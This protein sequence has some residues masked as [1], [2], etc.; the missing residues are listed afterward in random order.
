MDN[1]RCA[2]PFPFECI[3]ANWPPAPTRKGQP[4][5]AAGQSGGGGRKNR[6]VAPFLTSYWSLRCLAAAAEWIPLCRSVHPRIFTLH[7]VI[8]LTPAFALSPPACILQM[9]DDPK[10]FDPS[11]AEGGLHTVT[12]MTAVIVGDLDC[13]CE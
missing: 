6:F 2:R 3:L 7:S 8:S 4:A 10:Q 12:T 9:H 1:A 13:E 11:A 5:G